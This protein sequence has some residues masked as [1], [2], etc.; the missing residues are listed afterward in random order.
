MKNSHKIN[1][2]LMERIQEIL[3]PFPEA[4]EF[5]VAYRNYIHSIDDL[6]DEVQRPSSEQLLKVF[7]ESAICFSLPFWQQY[8]SALIV[9][10]Q[11]I[12]NTY[13]DSVD[14]ETSSDLM[15]QQDA[16]VLRHCGL[17]MFFAVILLTAGRE[18]LRE[19]SSD[20]RFQCH[21]LQT[22][23]SNESQA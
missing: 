17:D 20:F 10:E 21:Q 1:N 4:V 19:I 23:K 9:T 8:K 18:K 3:C 16:N 6:V 15:K 22:S 2:E 14:W 13:A 7:S 12:N 5:A 11:L